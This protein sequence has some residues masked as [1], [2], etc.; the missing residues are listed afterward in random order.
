MADQVV[1]F[2]GIPS[3]ILTPGVYVEFD[4][5]LAVQGLTNQT[6]RIILL[7][8]MLDT[9]TAEP[10]VPV[11]V[12]SAAEG[13]RLAGVGSIAASML[14]AIFSVTGSVETWLLPIEDPESGVAAKGTVTVTGSPTESGTLSLYV[15]GTLVQVGIGVGDTPA[16]VATAIAAAV[17][18]DADLPCT[19][20]ATDKIVTLT[21]RHKGTIGN[22]IDLRTNYYSSQK[23]VPGIS[24]VC[25]ACSGGSGT[26]DIDDAIAALDEKQY[27]T[28]ICAWADDTV[29]AALEAE[30]D[31]RWGPMY[32]NDGHL[33]VGFRGTVGEINTKLGTRNSPHVTVWTAEAGGEPEP[34]YL[35]A[36]L[37]GATCAY[38]LNIDPARPVQTLVLTGR[39]P[40][41]ESVRFIR[42]ERNNILSYGG[43]TTKV[44]A[45]GNVVIER[46]VTTY[47][48]NSSGLTDPSYRDIETMA[49]LS[50]LRYQV[51]ARISQ[52]FPRHKL[53]GDETEIPPGQAMVS[54][55]LIKAE[56]VALHKDWVDAGLVEDTEEFK[57]EL[58]VERNADDVNRVDVLLPPD[59]VNQFRVFAAKTEFR[60]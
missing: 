56:L 60:L 58:I 42:E 28:M 18:A 30:L 3:D 27:N 33:H 54:P 2:N 10:N 19:A 7:A 9:G 39:L 32:Q 8:P 50:R 36:A 14:S 26:P 1:D 37:A 29:L 13:K 23:D 57:N 4:N 31:K 25:V 11:Q 59:L 34:V 16:E 15:A 5:S 49:T 24:V 40:A 35:K 21:C 41:A 47:T 20:Q 55:K 48:Q 38:Y 46:A 43:A 52:K 51:R 6:N 53:C 45:G 17:N 22:D 44:D 12:T